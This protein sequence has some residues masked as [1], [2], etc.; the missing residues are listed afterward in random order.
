RDTGG[1]RDRQG[2][3][4]GAVR[5]VLRHRAR[6]GGAD[7]GRRAGGLRSAAG[8]D[9]QGPG[10]APAHL[11]ADRGVRAFRAGGT[12]RL[13]GADPPHERAAVSGRPLRARLTAGAGP[14]TAAGA[15]M[16]G[17]SRTGQR[18]ARLVALATTVLSLLALA[19]SDRRL[20]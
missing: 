11:R 7:P 14:V 12:R 20:W 2:Q 19:F 10:P 18:R 6:P 9:H 16:S 15:A 1:V 13:L 5:G 4:G 17:P 8:R 3:A